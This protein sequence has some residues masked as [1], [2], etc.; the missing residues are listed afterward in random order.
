MEIRIKGWKFTYV[1]YDV[2]IL[3]NMLKFEI[4]L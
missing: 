3:I 1:L 4:S 2:N